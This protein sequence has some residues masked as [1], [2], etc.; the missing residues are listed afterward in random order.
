MIM[1]APPFA[2]Q[3]MPGGTVAARKQTERPSIVHT[4][5]YLPEPA[6]EALRNA[7]H[8]GLRLMLRAIAELFTFPPLNVLPFNTSGGE[9][10]WHQQLKGERGAQGVFG[11]EHL[12]TSPLLKSYATT[13]RRRKNRALR[14][15]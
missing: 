14:S 9:R 2:R 13:A 8:A 6:Y 1:V 11:T 15:I 3:R 4:S 10:S 7:R 5:L 12:R